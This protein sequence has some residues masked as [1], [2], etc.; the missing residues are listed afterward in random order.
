MNAPDDQIFQLKPPCERRAG[1]FVIM[2]H[3][4]IVE[5]N[6]LDLAIEALARVKKSVPAAELRIYGR[7]TPFSIR[8]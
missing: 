2:Y 8:S 6:G 7:K 3:G 1:K 5:R 4:S